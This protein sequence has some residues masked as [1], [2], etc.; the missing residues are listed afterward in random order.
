MA[1]SKRPPAEPPA[2]TK[3]EPYRISID[4]L[5][6]LVKNS[7]WHASAQ[8]KKAVAAATPENLEE[9]QNV[10]HMA[11]WRVV[12]AVARAE[13]QAEAHAATAKTA[14]DKFY[15]YAKT[16]PAEIAQELQNNLLDV[17]ARAQV[18]NPDYYKLPN[19]K[20]LADQIGDI[21]HRQGKPAE[22]I[23][24]SYLQQGPSSKEEFFVNPVSLTDSFREQ[25]RRDVFRRI[26]A[27][28]RAA[29][30]KTADAVSSIISTP[31]QFCLSSVERM[32]R[33]RR[34]KLY[35][36][37]K[38]E[39]HLRHSSKSSLHPNWPKRDK[40]GAA[41]NFVFGGILNGLSFLKRE[42]IIWIFSMTNFKLPHWRDDSHVIKSKKRLHHSP[43]SSLRAPALKRPG[44]SKGWGRFKGPFR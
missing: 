35:R 8:F 26:N 5:K 14:L 15:A 21:V 33:I 44:R 40:L 42:A 13:P 20:S 37:R 1:H 39:K 28:S 38:N 36:R 41:S 30:N 25:M 29:V 4:D 34:I 32:S 23:A 7:D 3:A 12:A 16:Q 10:V 22:I 31:A 19:T 43:K 11:L 9:F 27:R 6:E 2:D 18:S 17:I 24:G